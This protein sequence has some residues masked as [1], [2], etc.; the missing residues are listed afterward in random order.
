MP[1]PHTAVSGGRCSL[2][3]VKL[4]LAVSLASAGA[5]FGLVCDILGF[6]SRPGEN[7]GKHAE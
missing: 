2:V 6:R 1:M 5:L 3:G 7:A 4:A